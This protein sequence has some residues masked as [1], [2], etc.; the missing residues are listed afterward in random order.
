VLNRGA[1]SMRRTLPAS[2]MLTTDVTRQPAATAVVLS[3]G[4]R[5]IG[6]GWK[7]PMVGDTGNKGRRCLV[8]ADQIV[9]KRH[10]IYLEDPQ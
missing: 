1:M 3:C 5:H 2:A 9:D 7:T 4:G 10:K 8:A 6:S